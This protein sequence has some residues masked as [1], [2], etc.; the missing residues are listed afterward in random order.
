VA[1]ALSGF[2]HFNVNAANASKKDSGT[3]RMMAA[4]RRLHEIAHSLK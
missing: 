4:P 3:I 1:T 2:A